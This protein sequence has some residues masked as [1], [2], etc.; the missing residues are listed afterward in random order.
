MLANIIRN[1][2]KTG[3]GGGG[4]GIVTSDPYFSSVCLLLHMDGAN[5]STT[6][7]DSSANGYSI[8]NYG[9]AAVLTTQ[10][11][12]GGA[13][14]Y[15]DG[16]GA[17]VGLSSTGIDFG[18]N[19]FTAECWV[20][21]NAN[22]LSSSAH[23]MG[24]VDASG[25]SWA[26]RFNSSRV[27]AFIWNNDGEFLPSGSINLSQWY[28]VAV[29]KS[30]STIMLF[31]GGT[32]VAS[33]TTSYTFSSSTEF[34]VGSSSNNRFQTRINAYIDDVRLTKV[35]RYTSNFTPPTQAHSNA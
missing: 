1:A 4:G 9:T 12:Y 21:L 2:K 5:N 11:K 20:Y 31:I 18:T 34:T 14:G 10:S 33:T 28:H 29:S 27:L 32:Q 8:T 6:F 22:P 3:I 25:S 7:T 15:F 35:A 19:D 16:S 23:V 24:K 26:L 30:G 13:S 17:R